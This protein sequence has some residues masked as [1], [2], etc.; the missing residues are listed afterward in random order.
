M[1]VV[2]TEIH[3]RKY[4]CGL[5]WQSLSH[6][7]ELKAEAVDLARRLNFDLM[8][9]RKDVGLAQAGYASSRDGA[10]AGML[11][12]GGLVASV[13]ALKGVAH[14]GRRRPVASWLAAFRLDD[15]RWAY[16]AVRD[17]SFLPSGDFAGTRAEVLDRLYADSGLGGWNA[18]IGDPE[19]ADQGFHNFE[20]ARLQDFLPGASSRRLWLSSAWELAPIERSHAKAIVLASVSV[21]A[22]AVMAGTWWQQQRAARLAT[23]REQALQTEEQRRAAELARSTPPPPWLGKP[24]PRELAR[25]CAGGLEFFAPGGWRLDEYTCAESK[26]THAWSRGDSV[27]SNLLESIPQ[28]TVDLSGEHARYA[29][30]LTLEAGPSEELLTA[31]AIL[32]PLLSRFQQLGLRLNVTEQ[33]APRQA[34]ASLPGVRQFAAPPPS[35]RTYKFSLQAGGLPLAEVASVLSQPGVRL[36]ALVY[37]QGDWLLEGVVYAN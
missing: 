6:P 18:I 20:A 11:S 36:N 26:A 28:A 32:R 16:F 35:W 7:R 15:D 27:L 14:E 13:I 34:A 25:A 29:Q 31:D 21:L 33:V 4:V 1:A 9:L 24:S 19:L 5:L 22:V 23:L 12:L 2:V 17:E 30:P 10:H 8:V 37:R 3:K